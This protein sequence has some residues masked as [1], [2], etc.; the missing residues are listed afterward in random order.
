[1]GKSR[2]SSK[3]SSKTAEVDSASDASS[4]KVGVS[5]D[6]HQSDDQGGTEENHAGIEHRLS[7]AI[8]ALSEK[9]AKA[10]IE[11]LVLL[12][13]ALKQRF[14]DPAKILGDYSEALDGGVMACLRHGGQECIR[15]ADVLSLLFLV[16]GISSHGSALWRRA[17]PKLLIVANA[18]DLEDEAGTLAS[19][20]AVAAYSVGCLV[21]ATHWP[22]A[23]AKSS[24]NDSVDSINNAGGE[25]TRVPH[26]AA[27]RALDLFAELARGGSLD[28]GY[29]SS[30]V[31]VAALQGWQAV[32]AA[33]LGAS[34]RAV[35][36]RGEAGLLPVVN[37]VLGDED[38]QHPPTVE[39][40]LE[41]G[42]TAV[43][44]AEA[45]SE[46]REEPGDFAS[47]ASGDA[48]EAWPSVQASLVRLS[49]ESHKRMSKDVKRDQHAN[50]RKLATADDTL[51]HPA[52]DSLRADL[53]G[54][55][56]AVSGGP[57]R[58]PGAKLM[59][60]GGSVVCDSWRE[61]AKLAL[62]RRCLGGDVGSHLRSNPVVAHIMSESREVDDID[63]EDFDGFGAGS[64]GGYEERGKGSE[65]GRKKTAMR[66]KERDQKLVAKETF[67]DE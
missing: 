53:S 40:R 37:E 8:A 41:A 48:E 24:V 49:T 56:E 28:D 23:K 38:G 45:S 16:L 9:R 59:F 10:R 66:V 61:V 32:A 21:N 26:E 6:S 46:A 22:G 36:L 52:S 57:D 14:G 51:L 15:A 42:L 13:S 18:R 29:M 17:A 4:V 31:R 35:Q 20:Q 27:C 62:L 39:L 25:D 50:F 2:G 63:D 34:A 58:W 44:L 30:A 7:G 55:A 54:S 47:V 3:K 19:A 1:M 67:L 65:A 43:L 64:S 12:A 60:P 33:A 5:E 11:G